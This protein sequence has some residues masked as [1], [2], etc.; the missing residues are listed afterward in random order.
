ME[1]K[2]DTPD[3]RNPDNRLA[4]TERIEQPKGEEG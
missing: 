1:S 3:K 4:D 2:V